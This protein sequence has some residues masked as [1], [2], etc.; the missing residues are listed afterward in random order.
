MYTHARQKK[1]AVFVPQ[2]PAA[3]DLNHE[4]GSAAS[5]IRAIVGGGARRA[6]GFAQPPRTASDGRRLCGHAAPPTRKR[7][8]PTR[9]LGRSLVECTK[10]LRKLLDHFRMDPNGVLP[11]SRY[12]FC[13]FHCWLRD[14]LSQLIVPS[15]AK[16]EPVGHSLGSRTDSISKPSSGSSP[17]VAFGAIIGRVNH[18]PIEGLPLLALFA[19]RGGLG[20]CASEEGGEALRFEALA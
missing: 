16:R 10:M 4:S 15:A 7:L 14:S 20:L 1:Q 19:A 9:K 2:S 6:S 8:K 5:R 17:C 11:R 12:A 13:K 3:F 18:P